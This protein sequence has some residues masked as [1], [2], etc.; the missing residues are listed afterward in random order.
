MKEEKIKE[1]YS[2]LRTSL[3]IAVRDDPAEGVL[4]SGGLDT[5]IIA[6][7]AKKC[8]DGLRAFTV[9]FE[10]CDKDVKYAEKV[11]SFLN[12]PLNV[13]SFG[14]EEAIEAASKLSNIF[15]MEYFLDQV[16]YTTLI[17][18]YIALR[19]AKKDVNSVYTGDGADE[20]FIGYPSLTS[21]VDAIFKSEEE[22]F[23]PTFRR[24]IETELSNIYRLCDTRYPYRMG[25]ALDLEVK[26]PFLTPK[27]REYALKI[28]LEYKVKHEKGRIWGKWILRK[29]FEEE[30]PKEIIWREKTPIDFG[31]GSIKLLKTL[32]GKL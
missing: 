29:A 3:S 21:F 1:S 15:T 17:P 30:L 14:E 12:L 22:I 4:L 11:A 31:T 20:L 6:L 32:R 26:Q 2:V 27:V 18:T 7:L 25:R 16:G 28:P 10:D 13:Y 24:D 23:G 5:S 19:F 8:V 9:T